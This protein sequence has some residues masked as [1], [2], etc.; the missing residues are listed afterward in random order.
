MPSPRP[1]PYPLDIPRRGRGLLCLAGRL[2]RIALAALL[3]AAL[4]I[5][6]PLGLVHFVGWPLPHDLP[7]RREVT[8]FLTTELTTSHVLDILACVLWPTWAVFSFDVAHSTIAAITRWP[9]PAHPGPRSPSHAL[10][11]ALVGMLT[12]GPLTPGPR[13]TAA[14]PAVH[15]EAASPGAKVPTAAVNSGAIP[16]LTLAAEHRQRDHQH[17]TVT[18]RPPQG[19]VY[20][21]LWR[22]AE[23]ALGDGTRWAEIWRLNEGREQPDGRALTS[24]SL[25]RPGWTLRL[26]DNAPPDDDT[27]RPSHD[28]SPHDPRER[29]PSPRPDPPPEQTRPTPRP[30]RPAPAPPQQIPLPT[31]DRPD[32]PPAA[33]PNGP[34]PGGLSTE[35]GAFVGLGLAALITAAWCTI[36]IRR[37]IHHRPGARNRDEP[38]MAPIVRALRLAHDQEHQLDQEPAPGTQEPVFPPAPAAPE[39]ALRERARTLFPATTGTTPAAG[40]RDGR[41]FAIALARTHGLGLTGPGAHGAARALL[42]TLLA[43]HHR[44]HATP[45]HVLIPAQDATALFGSDAARPPHPPRLRIT[46]DIDAALDVMEQELLTRSR[47]GTAAGQSEL[48][49]LTSPHPHATRRLQAVLDNGTSLGLA[50]I[51]LGPWQPGTTLRVRDDGTI[52]AT[53]PTAPS[54]LATGARLFTLPEDDAHDLLDLL[55]EPL[56]LTAP[57]PASPPAATPAP[58]S[59]SIPAAGPDTSQA[60]HPTATGEQPPLHPPPRTATPGEPKRSP[61][62]AA[63]PAAP[64]Q[65]L[66][67]RVCGRIRLSRQGPDTAGEISLSPRH[68]ELVAFLAL[69]R[70]GAHRDTICAALWPE[71]RR[72]HNAF[73]ATVSQIRRALL[74]SDPFLT[75]V[76]EHDDGHYRL[77]GEKVWTDLWNV[78]D[79]LDTFSTSTTTQQQTI[80]CRISELYEGDLAV[81]LVGPWLEAPREALRRE[82]LSAYSSHI[83]ALRNSDPAGALHFLETARRLDPYNEAVYRDIARQQARLGQQDEIPR[84]RA[85]LESALAEIDEQPSAETRAVIDAAQKSDAR[86][87]GDRR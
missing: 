81:D 61:A 75:D 79:E 1:D 32:P 39:A 58:S 27:K 10:A 9:R 54:S 48:V 64:R 77:N 5:G 8:G 74:V 21:S 66:R 76:V 82:I 26:P 22:I 52:A 37:R 65:V 84:T 83:R 28:P 43:D 86:R 57:V 19:G 85:L 41:T 14:A 17:R 4:L 35:T 3:L 56:L 34:D 51:L 25:I 55:R 42:T 36:R 62:R 12:L 33:P 49:L 46:E 31:P 45:L 6:T 59:A 2:L 18:V 23:R 47:T 16:A 72:P 53:S 40:I 73:H 87:P 29:T 44:P 69:H 68:R 80:L 60:P 30:S 24:P 70:H 11:A 50:G 67:L 15:L 78:Q 38:T 20:D 71:T 63:Q 7:T 13:P